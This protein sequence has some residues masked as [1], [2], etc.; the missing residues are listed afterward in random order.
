MT[1]LR[2]ILLALGIV[3]VAIVGTVLLLPRSG[4]SVPSTQTQT[5]P[6]GDR[7]VTVT[8]HYTDLSQES[9]A[10]GV[11]ITVDGHEIT[12]TGDE[13]TM[14]DKSEMLDPDEDVAIDVDDKGAVDV[15]LVHADSASPGNASQ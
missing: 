6:V 13:L 14:D 5:I 1:W 15:K 10:D 7:T 12:I 2:G 9:L 3:V 11:E 8:G 4:P